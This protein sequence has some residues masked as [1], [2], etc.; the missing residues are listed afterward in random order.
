M[1]HVFIQFNAVFYDIFI[2]LRSVANISQLLGQFVFLFFCWV[3]AV[4]RP[5]RNGWPCHIFRLYLLDK[6]CTAPRRRNVSL[7]CPAVPLSPLPCLSSPALFAIPLSWYLSVSSVSWCV[8]PFRWRP[9]RCMSSTTSSAEGRRTTPTT[10]LSLCV[11]LRLRLRLQLQLRRALPAAAA[12]LL[13][14]SPNVIAKCACLVHISIVAIVFWAFL[15]LCAFSCS[16]NV[17]L[18]QC[19]LGEESEWERREGQRGLAWKNKLMGNMPT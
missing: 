6:F 7:G 17:P 5:Y 12:F 9:Q 15:L 16:S 18:R 2:F 10:S 4:E 3:H 13:F 19:E 11:R 8:L 14:Y 1:S